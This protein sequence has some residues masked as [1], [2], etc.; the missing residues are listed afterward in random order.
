VYDASSSSAG[1]AS[2]GGNT[3][4]EDLQQQEEQVEIDTAAT[5]DTCACSARIAP[6]R[7]KPLVADAAAHKV[8]VALPAS[9]APAKDA[10]NA[11]EASGSLQE[12]T[13]ADPASPQ[14]VKSMSCDEIL[15][16]WRSLLDKLGSVL[17]AL[18]G[19]SS[20][21]H[22]D[23]RITEGTGSS[24]AGG[25]GSSA[26]VHGGCSSSSSSSSAFEQLEELTERSKQL[27]ETAMVLNPGEHAG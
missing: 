7:D 8:A 25:A 26:A 27:L 18:Q 12:V 5:S 11:Q 16:S 3:K 15:H 1:S 10:A 4:G 22:A 13:A 9:T 2:S 17:V 14:A 20:A 21:V 19:A 24:Y 6:V 23:A